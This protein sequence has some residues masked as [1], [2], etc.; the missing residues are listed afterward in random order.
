MLSISLCLFLGVLTTVGVAW[1]LAYWVA[2]D[3]YNFEFPTKYYHPGAPHESSSFVMG[4]Y[5]GVGF[6]RGSA[7]HHSISEDLDTVSDLAGVFAAGSEMPEL[8]G[9]QLESARAEMQRLQAAGEPRKVSPGFIVED[10]RGWPMRA[11]RVYWHGGLLYSP[12]P[13]PYTGARRLAPREPW[14]GIGLTPYAPDRPG[15]KSLHGLRAFPLRPILPGLLINTLFYAVLWFAILFGFST[16]RRTI[17]RARGRCL[18]CGYDLRG[19]SEAA[20]GC[21]ECGWGRSDT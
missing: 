16:S 3:P 14:W 2:I 21:P 15:T 8:I 6:D 7:L 4:R 5:R 17:R 9:A 19:T 20:E 1:G 12:N 11:L 18:K 10:S 13:A